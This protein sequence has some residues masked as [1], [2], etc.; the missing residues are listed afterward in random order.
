[1]Y[2]PS[3]A[4]E[5]KKW[6]RRKVQILARLADCW[7]NRGQR[8]LFSIHK[9]RNTRQKKREKADMNWIRKLMKD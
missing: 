5:E 1:M 7:K 9:V 6:S 4:W 8:G 3:E 2:L